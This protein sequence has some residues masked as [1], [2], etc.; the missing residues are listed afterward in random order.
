MWVALGQKNQVHQMLPWE[1]SPFPPVHFCE[2]DS[3]DK[4]FKFSFLSENSV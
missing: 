4:Y 3:D 1:Q 2:A